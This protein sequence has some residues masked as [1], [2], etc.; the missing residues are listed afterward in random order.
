MLEEA[1]TL[2]DDELS[3]RIIYVASDLVKINP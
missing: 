2:T 1:D 3:I